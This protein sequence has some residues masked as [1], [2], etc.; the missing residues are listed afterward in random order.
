MLQFINNTL[1]R[2]GFTLIELLVV[3]LIIGILAAVAVPQY[4]L[5]VDKAR[6]RAYMPLVRSYADAEERFYLANGRYADLFE[7]DAF[8]ISFPPECQPD[9]TNNN[10][11]ICGNHAS[12]VVYGDIPGSNTPIAAGLA[13]CFNDSSPCRENNYNIVLVK[14]FENQPEGSAYAN[15]PGKWGCTSRNYNT[16]EG[17]LCKV[18]MKL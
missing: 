17:K 6:V 3:V 12:L 14:V 11:L 2:K 13:Y 18:L 9:P 8:D 5:A 7:R 10:L 1:N 4:K 16:Y 15:S